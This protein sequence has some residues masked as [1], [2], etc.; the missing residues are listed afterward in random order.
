MGYVQRHG[1]RGGATYSLA[2]ELAPPPGL[3]LAQ[4]DLRSLVIGLAKSAPITNESVRERTGL[5]RAAALRL[6]S[7]LTNDG[8][9]VRHGSRRGTFYTLAEK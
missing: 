1:E 3:G 4:D 6:L 5:D 2:H 8:L 9:L 7:E